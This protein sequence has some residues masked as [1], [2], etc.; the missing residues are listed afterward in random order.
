MSFTRNRAFEREVARSAEMRKFLGSIAQD[1]A[2]EVEGRLP[3]PDIL[4]GLTVTSDT[5]QGGDGWEGLVEVHGPG[6]A[7]Y[8]F[9]TSLY[10]AKPAIRPGVQAVLSRHGGRLGESR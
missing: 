7:L 6:W 8:E 3:H 2:R 1:A 5:R 10:G 4:G 9:G